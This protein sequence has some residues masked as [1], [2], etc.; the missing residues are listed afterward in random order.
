MTSSEDYN[1][2]SKDRT[3]ERVYTSLCSQASDINEHLPTLSKYAAKCESI[4]ETGVRGVVSSWAFAH[5]LCRNGQ[6]VKRLFLNDIYPCDIKELVTANNAM[7]TPIELSHA[8]VNNLELQLSSEFDLTFID[9]WHVYG[10]LKRELIKFAPLTRKYII[11]HDT[12]V[13]ELHGE[14][15]RL[16]LDAQSQSAATGIPVAEI[17]RGIWPAV[18]EFL[19]RSVEWELHER[20]TNNN[21]LTVLAR[22]T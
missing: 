7:G 9:T 10:Q 1:T 18:E 5:G 12:T 14:T 16:G 2:L 19:D 13:D 11:L 17:T 8:W 22:R 20:F 15:L 4:F 21:G 3:V 6:P